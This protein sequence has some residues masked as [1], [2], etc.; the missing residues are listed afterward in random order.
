MEKIITVK[1][2][3]EKQEVEETIEIIDSMCGVTVI[4]KENF[5]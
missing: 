1:L 3:G 2:K 4:R 5:E